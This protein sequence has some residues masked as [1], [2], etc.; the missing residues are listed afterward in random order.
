MNK[1]INKRLLNRKIVRYQF[2]CSTTLILTHWLMQLCLYSVKERLSFESK[3]NV[4]CFLS[5]TTNKKQLFQKNKYEKI[6]SQRVMFLHSVEVATTT[7]PHTLY[8]TEHWHY[9]TQNLIQVAFKHTNTYTPWCTSVPL[10]AESWNVRRI[11]L[12]MDSML[13]PHL[14]K[15]DREELAVWKNKLL[16]MKHPLPIKHP[17]IFGMFILCISVTWHVYS[18]HDMYI[19][20]QW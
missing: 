20:L 10:S 1:G 16:Y 18:C 8:I 6:L 2:H 17:T 7:L 11:L 14:T 9:F 12:V 15:C 13:L 19:S 4:M 3:N 5:S